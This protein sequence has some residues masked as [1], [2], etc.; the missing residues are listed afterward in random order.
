MELG[1]P[2]PPKK[3]FTQLNG[4]VVSRRYKNFSWLHDRL[5]E[6]YPFVVIP[7]LPE[8]QIQG[9]FEESFVANRMRKLE[10]FLNRVVLHPLLRSSAVLHH[11]VTSSDVK[12]RAN[13]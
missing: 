2:P 7:S 1:G 9:R 12:V 11:F 10:R 4:E 5:T 6:Q 8:K 3:K 13:W